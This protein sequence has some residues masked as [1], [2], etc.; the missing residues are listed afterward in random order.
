MPHYLGKA[1]TVDKETDFQDWVHLTGSK[2]RRGDGP[3]GYVGIAARPTTVGFNDIFTKY[4]FDEYMFV[5]TN[6]RLDGSVTGDKYREFYVYFNA[7]GQSGFNE[8][9]SE[10][11]AAIS[12]SWQSSSQSSWSDSGS[13]YNTSSGAKLAG[14]ISAQGVFGRGVYKDQYSR[15]YDWNQD[16]FC[17]IFT[18]YRPKDTSRFKWWNMDSMM[19]SGPNGNQLF[20][21]HNFGYVKTVN[22]ITEIMFGF[23]VGSNPMTTSAPFFSYD[24]QVYGLS[25]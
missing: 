25:K 17:G 16:A 9:Q 19:S 6:V 22:A 24:I 1:P 23:N 21:Y 5:L 18:L 15:F 10:G 4:D 2:F 11:S 8:Y 7:V 3:T 20:S 13:Q 12:R 14:N